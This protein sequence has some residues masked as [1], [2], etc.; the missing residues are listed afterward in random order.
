MNSMVV[1]LPLEQSFKDKNRLLK[2]FLE[3]TQDFQS[4]FKSE[5]TPE[6]KMDWVDEL[7]DVREHHLKTIQLLDVQIET[8]KQCLTP[9]ESAALQKSES[10]KKT[11]EETFSLIRE[12][13]LTDQSLFL[14]IQNIGFELRAQIMKGLKEKET[15]SKFKSQNTATGEGLDH[16]V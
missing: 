16:T 8:L 5:A 6:Q 1:P 9:E 10:F 11:L 2:A 7:S 15:L 12:I 3:L 13:Q 4:K 14:Y